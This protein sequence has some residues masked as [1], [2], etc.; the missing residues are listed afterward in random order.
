MYMSLLGNGIS[1]RNFL[2][3]LEPFQIKKESRMVIDW[4]DYMGSVRV[5]AYS[6][7]CTSLC[8]R[9]DAKLWYARY[10]RPRSSKPIYT[11]VMSE[12]DIKGVAH[13]T[14]MGSSPCCEL[15][16]SL[17]IERAW[18]RVMVARSWIRWRQ[19]TTLGHKTWIIRAVIAQHLRET[20]IHKT[21]HRA[22]S[23]SC[24]ALTAITL[25]MKSSWSWL[26][27]EVPE[28]VGAASQEG[29]CGWSEFKS[30]FVERPRQPAPTLHWLNFYIFYEIFQI[31]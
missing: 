6:G 18:E 9:R 2:R 31:R 14:S 7:S 30:G 5:E 13:Y 25:H 17:R 20:G 10:D 22:T 24:L 8:M 16:T 28:R 26:E 3:S 15:S 4:V 12:R 23:W 29:R 21:S 27:A 1:L 11:A 19:D